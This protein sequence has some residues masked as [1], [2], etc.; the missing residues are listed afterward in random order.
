MDL[1]EL[2]MGGSSTPVVLT[3]PM[4]RDQLR[5]TAN[6]NEVF[7]EDLTD[8]EYVDV[9]IK[10]ISAFNAMPPIFTNYGPTDFPDRSM[11]MDW[12]TGEALKKL[13]LWH[14][15]NQWSA[16]DSGVTVPIHEQ[17]QPLLQISNMM[18]A[19]AKQDAKLLKT[20]INIMGGWGAGV[21]SPL[22]MR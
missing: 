5:D 17:W 15:R 8:D 11:I 2:L 19:E 6:F 14:V 22:W 10:S 7:K 12:A 1:R 20:Q 3:V 18:I 9:I 21:G 13:V 16:S 4:L